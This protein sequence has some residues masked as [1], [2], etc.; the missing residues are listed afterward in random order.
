[1]LAIYFI[2]KP[3]KSGNCTILNS[4]IPKIT[5]NDLKTVFNTN[6]PMEKINK[7]DNL[8][9]KLDSFINQNQNYESK[10]DSV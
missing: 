7:I 6:N 2:L 3:P 10:L 9:T 4:N 8:R 5:I 1:M